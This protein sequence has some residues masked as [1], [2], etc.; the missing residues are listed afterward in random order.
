M[1]EPGSPIT[2]RERILDSS[3]ELFARSGY[4]GSSIRD[5]AGSLNVSVSAVYN[6]FRSKDAIL[7]EVLRRP[8]V[9]S[10]VII[11]EELAASN[12]R[13]AAERLGRCLRLHYAFL[14]DHSLDAELISSEYQRLSA[15]SRAEI[16]TLRNA[17]EDIFKALV[18]A[19]LPEGKRSPVPPTVTVAV[20][21][22]LGLTG[23]SHRWFRHDGPMPA[24]EV[25]DF[26]VRFA[27]GGAMAALVPG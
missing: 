25:L 5:I 9:E 8:I 4:H 2:T 3:K 15:D 13:P 16:V 23:N 6:H 18:I 10:T 22:L 27:M 21:V 7:L 14:L 20:N 26:Y 1:T 17:F 24:G 12:G 19:C 11:T